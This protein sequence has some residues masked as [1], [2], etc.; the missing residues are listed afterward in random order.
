LPLI[1][2]VPD[3]EFRTPFAFAA[4]P[5]TA[6][7]TIATVPD[8]AFCTPL[9]PEELPPVTVPVTVPPPPAQYAAIPLELP[10]TFPV[11]LIVPVLTFRVPDDA[12]PAP[13]AGDPVTFTVPVELLFTPKEEDDPPPV[14][15]PVIFKVPVEVFVAP[16]RLPVVDDPVGLPSI[17]AEF[18]D[19]PEYVIHVVEPAIALPPDPESVSVIP[20][21]SVKPPPAT[22]VVPAVVRTVF[23]V[24]LEST[25]TVKP[26]AYTSSLIS[27]RVP[28]FH[29]PV[30]DQ[31]PVATA[32]LS[33]IKTPAAH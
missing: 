19:V 10:I 14:G 27:G 7:P 24:R 20:L 33:A 30:A 25:V 2:V 16:C 11:I 23:A 9:T 4:E 6:D 1:V 22:A 5:P 15:F 18:P 8:P 13:A 31:L 12:D 26:L 3:P 21:D 28:P 32:H 17:V 29:V